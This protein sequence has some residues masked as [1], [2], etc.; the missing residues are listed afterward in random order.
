MVKLGK[1]REKDEILSDSKRILA[2]DT[3]GGT[4]IVHLSALA[5]KVENKAQHQESGQT[6]CIIAKSL[7]KHGAPTTNQHNVNRHEGQIMD[8]HGNTISR[9]PQAR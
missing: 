5:F 8:T 2:A 6:D 4:G 7:D 1:R 9:H 3:T